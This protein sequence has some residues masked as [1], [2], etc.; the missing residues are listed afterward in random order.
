MGVFRLMK[1]MFLFLLV[2]STGQGFARQPLNSHLFQVGDYAD[3]E[4]TITCISGSAGAVFER[5]V[6]AWIPDNLGLAYITLRFDFPVNID[7]SHH[8]VF[9]D[10]VI[11]VIYTEF[12][13]GTA[14]WNM[15]VADCPSGW[16]NVFTQECEF[17]N[18]APSTIGLLGQFSMMRD[19]T[20]ILNDVVVLNELVLNDPGC[21]TV[22]VVEVYWD[23][24]KSCYR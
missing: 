10:R 17:L 24:L 7:F 3:E 15:I 1:M 11:D 5:H 20:F 21:T 2:F 8:P 12:T 4:R 19:C 16:I 13:G 23:G 14:E 18:S 22:P 6:W 9:H